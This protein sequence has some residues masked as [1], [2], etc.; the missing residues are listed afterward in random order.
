MYFDAPFDIEQYFFWMIMY[1]DVPFDVEQCCIYDI[2]MIITYSVFTG[3]VFMI[4]S[5]FINVKC[6]VVFIENEIL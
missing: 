1:F 6:S 4:L 3:V 2:W 5:G